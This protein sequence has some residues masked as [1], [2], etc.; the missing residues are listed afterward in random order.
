MY[1]NQYVS[2]TVALDA[3]SAGRL[4]LVQ[5]TGFPESET[6]TLTVL[7]ESPSA[8][9]SLHL[10]MP[11]WCET[12]DVRVNGERVEAIA[13]GT[14]AVIDRTWKQGDRV[15]IRLPMR[16]QWV[17]READ[18]AGYVALKRGPVVYSLDTVWWDAAARAALGDVPADLSQTVGLC[19][20]GDG[21]SV[22]LETVAAPER[23]LGPA[24]LVR[25]AAPGGTVLSVPMLPF[26]NTGC[27]Y[28]DDA[29]RPGKEQSAYAYAVW[30]KPASRIRE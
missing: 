23:A 16:L 12:P 10:R 3:G 13:P 22:D 6:V 2:S 25:V 15:E 21:L 7:P 27:W 5:E 20:E 9:F 29:S 18:P 30:L 24:C 26:A 8:A 11:P 19:D 17:E 4:T 14:Y 1:V 28:H